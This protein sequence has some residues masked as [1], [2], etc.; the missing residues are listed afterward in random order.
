MRFYN[1]K[2]DSLPPYIITA[3][4]FIFPYIFTLVQNGGSGR[5]FVF[6]TFRYNGDLRT[7]VTVFGDYIV[8]L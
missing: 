8:L 7:V 3:T 4:S 5:D 2:F 6:H 1:S